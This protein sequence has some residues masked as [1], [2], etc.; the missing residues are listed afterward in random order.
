LS[1]RFFFEVAGPVLFS[2]F[3]HTLLKTEEQ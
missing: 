1:L 3:I 2:F